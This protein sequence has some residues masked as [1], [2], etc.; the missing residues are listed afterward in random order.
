MR[1]RISILSVGI[2][3]TVVTA[4]IAALLSSSPVTAARLL[5]ED[6][7]S[8]EIRKRLADLKNGAVVGRSQS[9]RSGSAKYTDRYPFTAGD[10]N[11]RTESVE[12]VEN[13]LTESGTPSATTDHS[14]SPSSTITTSPAGSGRATTSGGRIVAALNTTAEP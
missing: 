12:Y 13:R 8:E 9:S 6:N 4:A 11:R 14:Y 2:L 5:L 3:L 7:Y 10:K 1:S